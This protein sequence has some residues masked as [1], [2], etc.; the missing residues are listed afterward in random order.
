MIG[1]ERSRLLAQRPAAFCRNSEEVLVVTTSG[2][3]KV[4][5]RKYCGTL[6]VFSKAKYKV[7]W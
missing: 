4:G 3:K 2:L 5:V 7:K 1:F 6:F